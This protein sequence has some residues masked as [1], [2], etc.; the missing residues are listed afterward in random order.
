MMLNT[1]LLIN[2]LN[3]GEVTNKG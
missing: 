2:Y 3:W 1:S